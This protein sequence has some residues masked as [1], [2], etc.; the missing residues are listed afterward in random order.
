[1]SQ[2]NEKEEIIQPTK[3]EL[4]AHAHNERHRIHSE[5]QSITESVRQ[6]MEPEDLDEPGANWK[7]VHHHDPEVGIQQ[8]RRQ[9]IRHWKTKAWKRRKAQRAERA[10]QISTVIREL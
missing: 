1:M 9:R 5:M 3:E 2:R 10:V 8:S 7:S 4:R 6:G